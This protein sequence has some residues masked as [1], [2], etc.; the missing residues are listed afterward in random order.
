MAVNVGFPYTFDQVVE[1]I[2]STSGD[3]AHFFLTHYL[4]SHEQEV[5]AQ[6]L[7]RL[8]GTSKLRGQDAM[9]VHAALARLD[10]AHA[11]E[12][13]GLLRATRSL[14]AKQVLLAVLPEV[15]PRWRNDAAADELDGWLRRRLRQPSYW[16]NG[17]SWE[18]P[19][20]ILAVLYCAD[21]A[22]ARSLLADL[23]PELDEFDRLQA[24]QVAQRNSDED[25]ERALGQWRR[26][27]S[28]S[29]EIS[30]KA[31]AEWKAGIEQEALR[32]MRRL[33]YSPA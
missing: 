13:P 19:C 4:L 6:R 5:G 15:L 25:F 23:I 26:K 2:A 18:I 20:V 14:E 31:A 12:L 27:D 29:S 3:N 8:L 21:A 33:G 32:C 28:S 7:R 24:T 9:L 17:A 11:L 22:R 30:T 10:P 1:A 16:E